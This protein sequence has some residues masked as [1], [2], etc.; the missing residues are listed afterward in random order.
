MQDR[1]T[2]VVSDMHVGSGHRK[3]VLNLFDD[4]RHDAQFAA[5]LR[6]Y[7][8]GS[9]EGS[10]VELVLNG[11]IFDLLKVQV[12][13]QFPERITEAIA[14]HKLRRCLTGHPKFV[15]SLAGFLSVR[16]KRISFLPGNHDMEFVYPAVQRAFCEAVTGQPED[17]RVHF[18]VDR[19][20]HR[21]EGGVEIHHGHQFEALHAFDWKRL[22][23]D[24]RGERILNLPWGSLFILNVI[25]RFKAERPYLDTIK[26][27]WPL[28]AGGAIFDPRFTARL[29]WASVVQ[30]FRGAFSPIWRRRLPLGKLGRLLKQDMR[31]FSD[32]DGYARRILRRNPDVRVVSMGHVHTETCR[33]FPGD[34]LYI[35]TGCWVPMV[36]LGIQN[37]G[38][39]TAPHYMLVRYTDK[40]L[41]RA[42]LMR[43]NGR[44]PITEE[45]SY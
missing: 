45:V 5:L 23:I 22:F 37:L 18:V 11:D 25:N 38:Q 26:P 27:F 1:I 19:P 42:S 4:F 3:G 14:L 24:Y 44:R 10:D 20:Q 9:Y 6:R 21:V 2:L 34:R 16:H 8:A 31:F 7:S 15:R 36:N 28:F 13:G 33:S 40:G 17:P 30:F 39:N 41:P 29:S 43:W 12:R 32:L 35:N